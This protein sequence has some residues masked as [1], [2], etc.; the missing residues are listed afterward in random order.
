M[1]NIS[2]VIKMLTDIHEKNKQI[3][4]SQ[5][6]DLLEKDTNLLSLY[7]SYQLSNAGL[8]NVLNVLKVI[9]KDF[10]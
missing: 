8:N 1:N 3:L 5:D 7:K 6:N 2:V 9:E 4:E 10:E